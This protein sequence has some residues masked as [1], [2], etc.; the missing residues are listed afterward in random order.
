MGNPIRNGIIFL[1]YVKSERNLAD[2][3]TK[4]LHKRMIIETSRVMRLKP[5]I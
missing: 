1:D 2:T 4:G 5:V 3:L